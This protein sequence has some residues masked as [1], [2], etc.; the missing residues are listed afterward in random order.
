MEL[1]QLKPGSCEENDV[2]CF[3]DRRWAR[4]TGKWHTRGAVRTGTQAS[5]RGKRRRGRCRRVSSG[6]TSLTPGQ[7]TARTQGPGCHAPRFL[8][9]TPKSHHVGHLTRRR[10][11]WGLRTGGRTGAFGVSWPELYRM[12][13]RKHAENETRFPE[14]NMQ[15]RDP[16]R[17]DRAGR[18]AAFPASGRRADPMDHDCGLQRRQE[19]FI[20]TVFL[21]Q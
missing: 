10:A 9:M 21:E 14:V 16:R 4:A 3:H 11:C 17:P 12:N 18:T 8:A 15:P 2:L 19:H 1:R 5:F 7:V 6:R 20:R 13:R